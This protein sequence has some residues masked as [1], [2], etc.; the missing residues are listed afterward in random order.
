MVVLY[1]TC[2]FPT[3]LTEMNSSQIHTMQNEFLFGMQIKNLT[4]AGCRI[5][6]STVQTLPSL[7][8]LNRLKPL[9]NWSHHSIH[10]QLCFPT[11]RWPLLLRFGVFEFDFSHQTRKLSNQKSLLREISVY[12]V[13]AWLQSPPCNKIIKPG[14]C[15]S[16]KGCFFLLIRDDKVMNMKSSLCSNSCYVHCQVCQ[17]G[18][19]EGCYFPIFPV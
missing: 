2:M 4:W 17:E 7:L 15:A 16:I 18:A 5:R 1:R 13:L 14:F 8:N 6:Y 9:L 19:M 10:N 11:N 3:T 12:C